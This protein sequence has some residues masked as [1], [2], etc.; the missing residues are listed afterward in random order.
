VRRLPLLGERTENES[1][2]AKSSSRSGDILDRLRGEYL[3]RPAPVSGSSGGGVSRKSK[4]LSQRA[5]EGREEAY[6]VLSEIRSMNLQAEMFHQ[7]QLGLQNSLRIELN[8]LSS[9]LKVQQQ[10]QSAGSMGRAGGGREGS[11]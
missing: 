5:R 6:R 3:E 4:A 2:V 11:I 1:L 7:R 8:A 10:Q 9:Q